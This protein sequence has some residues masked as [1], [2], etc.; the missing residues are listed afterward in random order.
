MTTK[1]YFGNF[2]FSVRDTIRQSR[3]GLKTLERSRRD[4]ATP[5]RI[6]G[7][8][9]DIP[10]FPSW[11]IR[12]LARTKGAKAGRLEERCPRCC[13]LRMVDPAHLADQAAENGSPDRVKSS[14]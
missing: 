13:V 1:S 14:E 2:D 8:L 3:A 9:R 7:S 4:R 6:W 12:R 11:V 10:N 5:R